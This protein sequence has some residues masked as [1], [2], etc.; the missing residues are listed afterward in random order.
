[1]SPKLKLFLVVCAIALP[2]AIL[3]RV[4]GNRLQPQVACTWQE[5]GQRLR[6]RPGRCFDTEAQV[7]EAT[8]R[9]AAGISKSD[10]PQTAICF[11]IDAKVVGEQMQ[12]TFG[13][14]SFVDKLLSFLKCLELFWI[15][16][17]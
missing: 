12:L 13:L 14:P 17:P 7:G 2:L 9:Q 3:I 16:L 15:T 8:I 10:F 4:V 5:N 6:R 1:M 11:A